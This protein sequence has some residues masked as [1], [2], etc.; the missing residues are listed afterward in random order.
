MLVYVNADAGNVF[1]REGPSRLSPSIKIPAYNYKKYGVLYEVDDMRNNTGTVW[2]HLRGLGWSMGEFFSPYDG[3]EIEP[4]P[5]PFHQWV[6][7]LD[8]NQVR[9]CIAFLQSVI[10]G[11]DGSGVD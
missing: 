5:D 10:D 11:G 4:K 3:G 8:D 6:V 9:E 2:Y 7:G 1:I